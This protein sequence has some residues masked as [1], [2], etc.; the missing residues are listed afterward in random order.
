MGSSESRF[1]LLDLAQNSVPGA[2]STERDIFDRFAPEMRAALESGSIDRVN[3]A[4][5]EM[6]VA[7]AE[8]LIELLNE[9]RYT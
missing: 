6:D 2:G 1:T 3:E 8:S 5:V 4:L 9:V 7:E